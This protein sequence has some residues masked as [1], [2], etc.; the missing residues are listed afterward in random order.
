MMNVP[1]VSTS[2]LRVTIE[3]RIDRASM[4]N[5]LKD[6]LTIEFSNRSKSYCVDDDSL[7]KWDK[8]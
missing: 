2:Q 3:K 8:R 6:L 7:S 1:L 5:N 4:L